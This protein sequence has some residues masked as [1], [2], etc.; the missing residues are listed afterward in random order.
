MFIESGHFDGSPPDSLA[1][2]D[3]DTLWGGR[4]DAPINGTFWIGMAFN[5][6][7]TVGSVTLLEAN[8]LHTAIGVALDVQDGNGWLEVCTTQ[9]RT[10]RLWQISAC[11]PP[12]PPS[13]PPYLPDMAP[14]NAPPVYHLRNF[15]VCPI[16]VTSIQECAFAANW[17]GLNDTTPVDDGQSGWPRPR[18]LRRWR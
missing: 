5:S 12:S 1:D 4:A 2:T 7:V 17:L 13:A 15:G 3:I 18:A 9:Q 11:V 6:E 8:P 16:Y 10:L 14:P